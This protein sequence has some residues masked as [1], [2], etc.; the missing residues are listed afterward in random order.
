MSAHTSGK[1]AAKLDF[2]VCITM[3]GAISSEYIITIIHN[4][5]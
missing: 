2:L 1:A 5:Q 4:E 3:S